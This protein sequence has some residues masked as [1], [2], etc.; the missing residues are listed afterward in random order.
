[1]RTLWK[2]EA[3]NTQRI[4]QKFKM[5]SEEK[6]VKVI[7][8]KRVDSKI[9]GPKFIAC[10]NMKGYKTLIE[11]K[12]IISTETEYEEAEK[13]G[14]SDKEKILKLSR[15]NKLA[16]EDILLSIN[17]SMSSGKIVFNLVDNCVT[18]DQPDGT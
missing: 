16:L 8:F 14:A 10:A 11:G 1:M 4:R 5:A 7:E 12:E 15:S 17:C 6:S 2:A 18:S 13:S 3:E 9:W